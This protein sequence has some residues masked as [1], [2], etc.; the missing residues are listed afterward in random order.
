MISRVSSYSAGSKLL[1]YVQKNLDAFG[2]RSEVSDVA[3]LWYTVEIILSKWEAFRK[4]FDGESMDSWQNRLIF[5][6]GVRNPIGHSLGDFLSDE[7][8]NSFS[9]YCKLIVAAIE[10]GEALQSAGA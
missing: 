7:D 6:A 10:R 3:P 5:C 4:Y 2:F 9:I 1:A 8:K